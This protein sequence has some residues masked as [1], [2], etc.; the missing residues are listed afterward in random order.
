VGAGE[1]LG[2]PFS[3][4]LSAATALRSRGVHAAAAAAAANCAQDGLMQRPGQLDGGW[5]GMYMRVWFQNL[6]APES[7]VNTTSA[8]VEHAA[9]NGV[10]MAVQ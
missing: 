1:V 4:V 8:E 10:H 9:Q 7:Q 5:Q 3:V 6:K 2:C